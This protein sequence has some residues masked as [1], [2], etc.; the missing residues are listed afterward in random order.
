MPAWKDGKEASWGSGLAAK[1]AWDKTQTSK[2][3]SGDSGCDRPFTGRQKQSASRYWIVFLES[4]GA[5]IGVE[6][7]STVGI[8]HHFMI[9]WMFGPLIR[10]AHRLPMKVAESHMQRRKETRESRGQSP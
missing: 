1:P 10:V 2:A 8:E 5:V 9:G 4:L 6:L 7:G 3:G